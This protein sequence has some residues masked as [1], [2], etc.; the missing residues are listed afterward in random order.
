MRPLLCARVRGFLR[1]SLLGAGCLVVSSCYDNNDYTFT[2]FYRDAGVV[3][4]DFDGDGTLDVAVAQSYIGGPPPHAG[5]V[6]IYLQ[7]SP[8]TFAPPVRYK[9]AADPWALATSDI[10]GT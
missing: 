1:P 5:Y 8:G 4:A 9:V 10:S 7:T 2:P 3:V 6:T